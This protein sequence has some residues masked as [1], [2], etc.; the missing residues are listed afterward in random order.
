MSQEMSDGGFLRGC[1]IRYFEVGK[2][3]AHRLVEIEFS[4]FGQHHNQYASI[5]LRVRTNLEQGFSGYILGMFQV[6]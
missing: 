3:S 4:L 2:V 5:C 6:C 1:L